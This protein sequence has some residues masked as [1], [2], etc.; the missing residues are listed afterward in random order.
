MSETLIEIPDKG[1]ESKD[2]V[3]LPDH[4]REFLKKWKKD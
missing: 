3:I 1:K 2:S 4:S